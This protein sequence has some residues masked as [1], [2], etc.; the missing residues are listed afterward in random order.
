MCRGRTGCEVWLDMEGL[1]AIL[2][3]YEREGGWRG[4]RREERGRR[5]R[6]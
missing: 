6:K 4:W 2:Y 5:E 3:T 1:T